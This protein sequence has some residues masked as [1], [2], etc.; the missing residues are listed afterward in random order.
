MFR[1]DPKWGETPQSLL[2][3]SLGAEDKHLRERLMA[4]SLVAGGETRT[5]V[6]RK[7]GR[8][9]NAITEWIRRFNERGVDGLVSGW[10][11]NPGK[12]LT[13]QEL[14]VVNEAVSRHPRASGLTTGR[15][16]ALLVVAFV[17]KNF[18]K[19][20]GEET[21][22]EYLHALGYRHKIPLKRLIKADPEK[23]K[24]F[25]RKLEVLERERSPHAV[26]AYV[27]QGQIWQDALPRKGWFK[28]GLPAEVASSSP[29]K[30]RRSSMRP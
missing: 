8:H 28:K 25:A 13:D 18:G 23:Q 19:K 2:K 15:W 6:A 10:K 29:G 21:A 27:D 5:S 26:T 12:I 17:E 9:R 4:V 7:I 14:A 11:G 22:R 30:K 24:Q 1:I 20:I 16:T 3:K